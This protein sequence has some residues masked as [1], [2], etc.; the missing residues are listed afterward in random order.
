MALL[1]AVAIL[2]G[3]AAVAGDLD[4][5][6]N[7]DINAKT[8]RA[9]L[10]QLAVQARVQLDVAG[11]LAG[12][13]HASNLKGSYTVRE[14][15]DKLLKGTALNFVQHGDTVQIKS[16]SGSGGDSP[17]EA[18]ASSGDPPIEA[19]Q[20]KQGEPRRHMQTGGAAEPTAVELREVTVTGTHIAGEPPSSPVIKITS[21]DIE[22]SGYSTIG[23]LIRSLPENFG[24]A[25]PQ[26]VIGSTPNANQSPSGSPAPNLFGLGADSTLTLVD[27]QRL[28]TDGPF[29]SVDIS[30]IPL[31][32]IDHIDVL[33]GGASAIY[34]SDAVAGV[35]NIVLRRDFNGAKTT[36]LGGGTSDG[37]GTE[38]EFNQMFG[39]TWRAGGVIFDYEFD[40][41][42]PILASQRDATNSAGPLT[43]ASPGM[44]RNSFFV[45]GH[46]NFGNVD[47][48]ARGLYTYRIV[49]DAFSD[50]PLYP[51]ERNEVAV[52]QYAASAGLNAPLPFSWGLSTV[53]DYSEQRSLSTSALVPGGP[54]PA[55]SYEGQARSIEVTANGP[56]LTLPSG[57]SRGA[58]GAGYRLEAYNAADGGVSDLHGARRTVEYMYGELAIPLIR[59]SAMAWRRSLM[60]NMSGRYERYSDFGNVSVPKLGLIYKP[61]RV[62]TLRGTWGRAF[63]APSLF[64]MHNQQGI[65]YYRLPD[66]LSAAGASNIVE[67]TGGNNELKPET[68][69]TW[70]AGIDYRSGA[71]QGLSGSVTYLHIVYDHRIGQLANPFTALT[72]PLNAPFVTRSPSAQYVQ[73][74]IDSAS[75]VVNLVGAPIDPANVPAV[76][77]LRYVNVA[78]QDVSGATVELKYGERTRF[79]EV[80]PFLNAAFLDFRQKLV[81]GAPEVEISGKVF[82]PPKISARGG[83]SWVTGPWTVSG[84]ANYVGSEANTYQP[85]TPRVASWTTMDVSVGF[86]PTQT[87]ELRGLQVGISVE[88]V[89]NRAPPYV[90]FDQ[91]VPGV[92]YDPLNANVFGREVRLRVSWMFQ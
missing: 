20:S 19:Q 28:A 48:F 71:V 51:S 53:G 73:S 29:G 64:E 91:F 57:I 42:N 76:V 72:D 43:T 8:L 13:S 85:T 86:E 17:S 16:T 35:V 56:V 37:G 18:N 68:A 27:G 82:E 78:S 59:S 58:I 5:V 9:A 36:L 65:L 45:S 26:T 25:N 52:H 12:R 38:R 84:F 89:F 1:G 40:K 22:R 77:N 3:R 69:D 30:L 21:Q 54:V 81:V 33:T 55:L 75:Y 7:L 24:N 11:R 83:V 90:Q 87:R 44:S 4:K 32:I 60:L 79:G 6:V 15:L 67:T 62:V 70:T 46:Q 80:E 14:A 63:R 31:P 74:L 23:D 2:I 10:V 47:A 50:G 66:A 49:R 61:F 88:N 34:G 92:H 39:K 41:Q